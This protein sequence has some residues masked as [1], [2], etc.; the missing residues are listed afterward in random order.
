MRYAAFAIPG[1]L[2]VFGGPTVLSDEMCV[3]LVAGQPV[4][5]AQSG[6]VG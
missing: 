5:A 4:P 1:F 3:E 2:A 6:I